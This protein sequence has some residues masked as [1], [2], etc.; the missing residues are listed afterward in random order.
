MNPTKYERRVKALAER[1][2]YVENVLTHA[3]VAEL[4]SIL[5]QRDPMKRLQVFHPEVDDLGFDLVLTVGAEVRYVQLKQAHNEK[6]PTS[7]S[8]RL[9][10][11][12]MPNA[13][14]V[15]MAH[16]VASLQLRHFHFFGGTLG[17]PLPSIEGQRVSVS[18]GRRSATGEKKVRPNY[19]DVPFRLFDG[20][21]KA[22]ELFDVLFPGANDSGV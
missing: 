13:C 1:S 17:E 8:I 15:L 6:D 9:S 22:V 5:W 10:F 18:P 12:A 2:S 14:V 19:R 11:A 20:P 7:P 4:S 21:L 16:S 3:L